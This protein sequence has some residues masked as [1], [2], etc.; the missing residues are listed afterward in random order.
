VKRL[1]IDSLTTLAWLLIGIGAL[2]LGAIAFVWF[3]LDVTPG[4]IHSKW[5]ELSDSII[6]KGKIASFLPVG[7]IL[8]LL[9][10]H[11]R[12]IQSCLLLEDQVDERVS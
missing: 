10:W 8:L 11:L 1:W 5:R 3:A 12:K 7:G 6:L 9:S 2:S 4:G